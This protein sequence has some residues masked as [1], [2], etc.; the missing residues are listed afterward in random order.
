M[1][2]PAAA[3][4]KIS[5]D[6][7]GPI[8]SLE[9]ELTKWAQN[10]IY[11]RNG[12]GKSFLSRAFRCLD[13]FQQGKHSENN[14]L[15]L[16]SEEAI[17]G[18]G[19]FR[20]HRGSSLL[21]SL[22]LNLGAGS[23]G[24]QINSTLFHVFSEDFIEEELRANSFEL[25]DE[26]TNTISV[27]KTNIEL[28]D[29]E[30]EISAVE[31]QLSSRTQALVA[32]FESER[33]SQLKVKA[34]ISGQLRE[35]KQLGVQT[36]IESYNE[37][38][39][40][41][42]RS[43]TDSLAD[44]DKLRSMPSEID[45]PEDVAVLDVDKKLFQDTKRNLKKITSPASVASEV[46][47][48]IE[49]DVEFF[50]KGTRLVEND[51][52]DDCPFCE[53][54][55][56]KASAKGLID[57]Y[58]KYFNDEE[59]LH[60]QEL[61]A[62]SAAL[63]QKIKDITE[64]ENK[65][66]RRKKEFDE[67]KAYLPSK[68]ELEL[69]DCTENI[70]AL[71]LSISELQKLAD[72]KYKNL[73][74][75]QNYQITQIKTNY[76]NLADKVER[77]NEVVA[78]VVAKA[79]TLEEER[80]SIQRKLCNIFEVEFVRD[81]WGKFEEIE[82]T[83]AKLEQKNSEKVLLQKD[84]I[85]ADAKARVAQTFKVL[86]HEFFGEKYKFDAETFSLTRGEN[87]MTRGTHRTLSDGEKSV[88]AFC[89]FIAS[90][91][92]KVSEEDDY[93]KLFLV[94]DDPVT[95]MSY[96]HVF[97]IVQTLKNL[98][99]SS[100]GSVSLTP[101]TGGKGRKPNLLILTHSNYFFNIC[102]TNRVVKANAAFALCDIG[103]KH[104]L[105]GMSKYVAPFESQLEHIFL[106]ANGSDPDHSTCN[107]IRSVL[108]AIGRFCMPNKRELT[109]FIVY[110]SGEEDFPIKSVLINSMSHG[111]YSD[112]TPSPQD[113]SLACQETVAVVANYAPGQIELLKTEHL[114]EQTT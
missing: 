70:D 30:V 40:K 103:G 73:A 56:S 7:L 66:S 104:E 55:V 33:T 65:L 53:Q 75:A 26:I 18:K 6:H 59:Q 16:V 60:K 48:K 74:I 77:N 11:A 61:K 112:I 89:Y 24:E 100:T 46:K 49:Q 80:K 54:D 96:D 8:L 47:E 42:T 114:G 101:T 12:T 110:L 17:G 69:A 34:K 19:S 35:Y 27:G 86:L 32:K 91:H 4:Y 23:C 13:L 22:D 76:E 45:I 64:F 111:S 102:K 15:S 20:F 67:L 2:T 93:A 9:C 62:L 97:S 107:S 39:S 99:I 38:P 25:D 113:I 98:N 31:K 72:L 109:E 79:T 3:A 52:V 81:N 84:E 105:D 108:E 95:S 41:P 68:K 50:K 58:I 82:N 43:I 63:N 90:I 5:A 87:P 106:V 1:S 94:F 10:I 29:I 44:L 57:D 21:G 85:P 92:K 37:K 51:D 88:L 83:K 36:C 71:K 28:G 14:P 78:D